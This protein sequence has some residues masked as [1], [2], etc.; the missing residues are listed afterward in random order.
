MPAIRPRSNYLEN[1]GKT[2]NDVEI[3]PEDQ[4]KILKLSTHPDLLYLMTHSVAPT[5]YG[6]TNIKK[7]MVLHLFGGS[8]KKFSNMGKRRSSIHI[9]VLGDPSLGKSVLME[10][11]N[12][13]S[14]NSIIASGKSTTGAGLT[15]SAVKDE[16]GAW[17]LEAGAAIMA[18][19][20]NL[21]IDEF[22]KMRSEDR[23]SLHQIM[24]QE[25]IT[26]NKA[27]INAT[28]NARCA[29]FAVAN[30]KYSKY[31]RS[32]SIGEQ[33]NLPASLLSR[34]DIIFI[35]EDKINPDI[36]RKIAEHITQL[37]QS[38][39]VDYFI[40]PDLFSKYISYAKQNIKPVIS[41]E[42][43]DIL[44]NYYV[45][46]RG[47]VENSDEPTPITTRQL[48]GMIRLTEASAKLHL[49]QEAS[50]DD[51]Q[52]AIDMMNDFLKKVG[53][54]PET[55]KYDIQK[56]YG[57]KPKSWYDKVRKTE[58]LLKEHMEMYGEYKEDLF[59]EEVMLKCYVFENDAK[60]IIKEAT[61]YDDDA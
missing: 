20:G 54:D 22:D 18:N 19:D 36:D 17:T 27:G 40:E 49:R 30:P 26:V 50:I 61:K 4:E 13:L 23:A 11:I 31:D 48:E 55:G 16:G 7:G 29:I 46:I 15:A 34:F 6:N 47:M 37:H 5:I 53:Y 24:E 56:L 2:H 1:I 33:I 35:M 21:C 51:A 8:E 25:I 45:D 14:M 41:D 59:I 43:S 3:T 60:K 12:E 52:I 28:L 9:L 10:S 58:E 39:N 57:A 38:H 42:V 44:V 32:K